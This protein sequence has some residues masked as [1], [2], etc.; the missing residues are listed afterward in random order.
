M[1]NENIYKKLL[2]PE[3]YINTWKKISKNKR[4]H[5]IDSLSEEEI[6]T[7]SKQ[8]IEKTIKELK[9]HKFQ[10]SPIK[11]ISIPISSVN[12]RILGIPNL[13]D[14]IIQQCMNTL[15]S[16]IYENIF[17]D[18]SHGF[19]PNRTT[20]TALK[21]IKYGWNGIKWF[22]EGDIKSSFNSIDHHILE[23]LLKEEIDD[24]EFIDLYWKCVKAKYIENNNLQNNFMEIPQETI[25]YQIL[26][27]IY[28]H[29]LDLFMQNLIKE[30][31][32][33]GLTTKDH[34]EYKKIHTKISNLRQSLRKYPNCNTFK[35]KLT[36]IKK[37]EKDC[38]RLPSK[39]PSG[40]SSPWEFNTAPLVI[41]WP[42][43]R[44]NIKLRPCK[45]KESPLS[46]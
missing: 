16:N 30:S 31:K 17:L 25:I 18:T 35:D 4:I 5:T 24:K 27:N 20:H 21:S 44:I 36:E 23:K 34:P 41:K 14:K 28:L 33:S 39:I 7:Y 9:T 38:A 3:L 15:L 29:K 42:T 13:R 43:L 8:I 19:R 1:K 26:S 12:T 40:I 32:K 22:I 10:F 37:L 46:V 2:E 45:R 6:N 11:K